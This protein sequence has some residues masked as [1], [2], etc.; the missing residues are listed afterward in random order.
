[1]ETLML[2][3]MAAGLAGLSLAATAPAISQENKMSEYEQ[4]IEPVRAYVDGAHRK[5]RAL[6]ERAFDIDNAQMKSIA[7]DGGARVMAIRDV[8]ENIWLQGEPASE[9]YLRVLSFRRLAENIATVE[10]DNNGVFIDQL[11]L[12]RIDDEWRI[13][14]KVFARQ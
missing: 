1:M 3:F 4:I 12:F 10:I 5:E 8:I 7:E 13:V 11:T 9:Y 14:D 2:K 6:L